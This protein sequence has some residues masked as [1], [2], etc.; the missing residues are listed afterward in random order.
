MA[1][2]VKPEVKEYLDSPQGLNHQLFK[3]LES[4][5]TGRGMRSILE[6]ISPFVNNPKSHTP[7]IEEEGIQILEAQ[8][9]EFDSDAVRRENSEYKERAMERFD[10]LMEK[11]RITSACKKFLRDGLDHLCNVGTEP[12]KVDVRGFNLSVGLN[13]FN[14][15][16]NDLY[17]NSQSAGIFSDESAERIDFYSFGQATRGRDLLESWLDYTELLGTG[18]A[19]AIGVEPKQEE[20]M[21]TTELF[22]EAHGIPTFG[23][24]TPRDALSRTD[25]FLEEWRKQLEERYGK[26]PTEEL[27]TPK[28][29]V[30]KLDKKG[31]VN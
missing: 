7:D 15:V 23:A 20:T 5:P 3:L 2:E 13:V 14:H 31:R 28:R 25:K 11:A 6:S 1:D 21:G 26:T 30:V 8:K 17:F 27:T 19:K 22:T 29:V 10:K 16:V 24:R 4:L 9:R 18:M 12:K